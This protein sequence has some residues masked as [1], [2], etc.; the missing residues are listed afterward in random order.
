MESSTLPLP[1]D[2]RWRRLIGVV[3]FLGIL[4]GFRHLAVVM[5]C[6]VILARG[7]GFTA[8]VVDRH[9]PLGPKSSIFAVLLGIL[10]SL[11]LAVFLGVQ[12]LLPMIHRVRLEGREYLEHLADNPTVRSI[13]RSTGFEGARVVETAKEHAAEAIKYATATAHVAMYLLIGLILGVIYLFE[14]H[15]IDE[16]L[17]SLRPTSVAGTLVRWL[18]YVGDAVT[19][20]VRMQLVV[21]LVNAVVTLPVLILLGLPR[22][23]L[24]FVLILVSGLLP[25]VG[26]GIAGAVLC[27]VAYFVK[28][29]WAVG[30]FLVVTFVLHKV[31]SYY[32]NPRLAAQHVHLPGLV[33]VVSLLLFEHAF[34]FAGLFLSFPALYVATRI[35][36]EWKADDRALAAVEA[37]AVESVAETK[38]G[39]APAAKPAPSDEPRASA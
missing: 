16:W 5:V 14:R 4:Y 6:A 32:L 30:V 27:T 28:G 22:V 39:P 26:N 17:R 13:E 3:M 18:G 33:L 7:L 35:H 15:E 11:A 9:T 24:L 36:N 19:I 21:A 1:G 8:D 10:G 37:A 23:P 29:P 38:P 20:T 2:L 12:R 34:G 31:E 25:V